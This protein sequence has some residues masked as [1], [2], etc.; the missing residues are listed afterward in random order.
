MQIGKLKA[1]HE[2]VEDLKGD[3]QEVTL[4][5]GYDDY[6]TTLHV[7]S[8]LSHDSRSKPEEIRAAAKAV[9]VKV[10]MF[11]EHPAPHYDYYKDGHRGL[12]DGVLFIP[13]AESNGLQCYPT[14]S[15]K[16]EKLDTPQQIVD[17]V[18][19]NNGMAFLCHLEERMDWE[20]DNLTGS[21]IYNT[22]ADFKDEKRFIA[23]LINP[24]GL[25]QLIPALN[26]YPQEVFAALQDYPADYLRR[27]DELCQKSRLTGISANDAHHNQGM[28]AI[29]GEDGKV[30]IRDALDEPLATIDPEKVT[31][32]K[33]LMAGKKAGDELFRLDLDPYERSLRH[34]STH[35]LMKEQTEESVREAL[36]AG[37][38]YVSFDWI[39]D[40]TGFTYQAERDDE[41]FPMGSEIASA[42]GLQLRAEAPLPG[43]FRLI[44]NGKELTTT[45]GRSFEYAVQEPG[46]YRLEVWLNLAGQPQI[47]ILSNP[48]YVR[49]S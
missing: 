49:G 38:A 33:V 19:Q 3:R 21:E 45:R 10:V 23:S 13:G 27:Y 32:L 18:V 25:L 24:I 40:P 6:R 8:L 36:H 16:D 34:V 26:Q 37:R 30:H 5:S 29:I 17:S 14:H 11:T 7:H 42:K 41:I 35:L 9:G 12:V 2:A 46:I 39:A 43:T 31:T 48:I 1:I 28:R 22:H 4:K 44:R 15:V 20:L 47:W